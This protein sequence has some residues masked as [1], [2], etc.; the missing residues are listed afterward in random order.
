MNKVFLLQVIKYGI[1][2]VINTI[3]TT[4]TIWVMMYL[5]FQAKKVED[6][7]PIV[8]TVSNATG[9]IAGLINSFVWNRKWTF[10]S[11]N[12]WESEFIKFTTAF[13]ICFFPQLLLVNLLN[14]YTNFR[15]DFGS[16]V[17]SHAYSCQLIGIIFYTSVNFFLNKFF[18]FRQ[19]NK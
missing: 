17:I 4:V 10:K 14:T 3:V 6:V 2:G 18:T 12:R 11:K 1:V 13:L 9:F 15:F 19:T 5:V 8:I 16:W 7:S